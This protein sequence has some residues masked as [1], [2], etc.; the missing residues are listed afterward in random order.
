MPPSRFTAGRKN[1]RNATRENS[2]SG[3]TWKWDLWMQAVSTRFVRPR[4]IRQAQ[5]A[6]DAREKPAKFVQNV[7]RA[8]HAADDRQFLE[9][10]MQRE[11]KMRLVAAWVKILRRYVAAPRTTGDAPLTRSSAQR[12]STTLD[13]GRRTQRNCNTV[14]STEG[15]PVTDFML[16]IG[17]PISMQAAHSTRVN[18][19]ERRPSRTPWLPLVPIMISV[20]AIEQ[21][22][23]RVFH[24]LFLSLSGVGRHLI[25]QILRLGIG[26]CSAGLLRLV[27]AFIYYRRNR[28]SDSYSLQEL[29]LPCFQ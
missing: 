11:E 8:K 4:I 20:Y 9:G 23:R 16:T 2:A 15:I 1:K 13:F 22:F 6:K 29:Y 25:R 5:P 21:F 17:E 28:K 27:G 19:R 7:R 10:I 18:Q 12:R 24:D 26:S 3:I 14:G